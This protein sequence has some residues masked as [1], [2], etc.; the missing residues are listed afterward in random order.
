[1]KKIVKIPTITAIDFKLII[2]KFGKKKENQEPAMHIHIWK[3]ER[4]WEW[5]KTNDFSKNGE[6][7]IVNNE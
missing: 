7:D 2:Q 4:V 6:F 3:V 5:M 1:M